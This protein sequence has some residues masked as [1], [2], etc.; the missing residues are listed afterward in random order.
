MEAGSNIISIDIS[1]IP[2][3]S[4]EG[5]DMILF[6]SKILGGN[7]E[8]QNIKIRDIKISVPINLEKISNIVS[9][10]KNNI[11]NLYK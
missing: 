9:F 3:K 8:K 5:W 7:I 1:H 2:R 10:V 4:T 6:N 11:N